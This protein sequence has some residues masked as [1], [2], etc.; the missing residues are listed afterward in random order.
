M[1]HLVDIVRHTVDRHP[2]IL[3][4]FHERMSWKAIKIREAHLRRL[5][6]EAVQREEDRRSQA[7]PADCTRSKCGGKPSRD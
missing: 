2:T 5:H 3:C 6:D 4:E 7:P 1:E